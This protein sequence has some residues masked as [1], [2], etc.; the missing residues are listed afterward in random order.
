VCG[1]MRVWSR[2]KRATKEN[3]YENTIQKLDVFVG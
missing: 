3:M 2:G 1:G